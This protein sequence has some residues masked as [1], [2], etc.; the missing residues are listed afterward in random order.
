MWRYSVK[1][2]SNPLYLVTETWGPKNFNNTWGPLGR[3]LLH[4][5]L[6][7]HCSLGWCASYS[8]FNMTDFTKFYVFVTVKC[9]MINYLGDHWKTESKNSSPFLEISGCPGV[10]QYIIHLKTLLKCIFYEISFLSRSLTKLCN[11]FYWLEISWI[12][13]VFMPSFLSS[14]SRKR[15]KF[16]K[17]KKWLFMEQNFGDGKTVLT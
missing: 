10:H 7:H 13:S 16:L 2:R 17:M 6:L 11:F 8:Y 4:P 12:I 3:A 14:G 5:R 1:T 9:I 15:E